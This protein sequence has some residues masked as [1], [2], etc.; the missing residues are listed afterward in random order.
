MSP[1]LFLPPLSL[2]I[3]TRQQTE[4]EQQNAVHKID[5]KDLM[6]FPYEQLLQREQQLRRQHEQSLQ[7]QRNLTALEQNSNQSQFGDDLEVWTTQHE[8]SQDQR[9]LTTLDPNSNQRQFD[10]N[11]VN[12]IFYNK[13]SKTKVHFQP[14][15]KLLIKVSL[16]MILEFG[17]QKNITSRVRNTIGW[18]TW[19][20]SLLE[21]K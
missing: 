14:L 20:K 5:I 10:E 2:D 18:N 17:R 11:N 6:L 1:S 8:Q 7:D 21:K 13:A 4:A 9:N 19:E 3:A 16:I 12:D 15:T